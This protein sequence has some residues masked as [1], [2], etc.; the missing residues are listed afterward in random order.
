MYGKTFLIFSYG[1]D[2]EWI[3]LPSGYTFTPYTGKRELWDKNKLYL[4]TLKIYYLFYIVPSYSVS[5][6]DSGCLRRTIL[7]MHMESGKG[8]VKFYLLYLK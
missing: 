4:Q 8:L 2:E 7:S 5:A 6:V 1:F 3:K